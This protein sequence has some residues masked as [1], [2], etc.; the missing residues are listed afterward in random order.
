MDF[1]KTKEYTPNKEKNV[2]EVVNDPNHE[3]MFYDIKSD[4]EKITNF[5][6]VLINSWLESDSLTFYK[7][8][9]SDDK[10]FYKSGLYTSGS[11]LFELALIRTK[12]NSDETKAFIK[13]FILDNNASHY[14]I[15]KEDNEVHYIYTPST[16]DKNGKTYIVKP[17]IEIVES[18]YSLIMLMNRKF[19]LIT[20][21]KDVNTFKDYFKVSDVPYAVK[22]EYY[23][24]GKLKNGEITVEEYKSLLSSYQ[25]EEK[26][27]K[28][29][30]KN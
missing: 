8:I 6:R 1:R 19:D 24:E 27:V 26:V 4:I 11:L 18:L 14:K 9:A 13:S 20:N 16:I 10:W 29:L 7:L 2:T 3:Y 22:N 23:L 30:K 15:V 12:L 5:K 28:I 25:T 17:V 21:I